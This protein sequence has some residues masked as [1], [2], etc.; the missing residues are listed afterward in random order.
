MQ[1]AIQSP[2]PATCAG[3][4]WSY[5]SGTMTFFD[6]TGEKY[7]DTRWALNGLGLEPSAMVEIAPEALSAELSFVVGAV[8]RVDNEDRI[9]YLG[10]NA[11]QAMYL[12]LEGILTRK[13]L[14][15][16]VEDAESITVAITLD[17]VERKLRITAPRHGEMAAYDAEHRVVA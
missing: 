17:G 11:R 16:A 10:V 8:R 2:V 9:A 7:S 5:N 6:T 15:Q 3:T 14:K 4:N 12:Y 13:A 1:S